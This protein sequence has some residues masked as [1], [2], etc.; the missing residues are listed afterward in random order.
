MI[1]R[2]KNGL[3]FVYHK[4]TFKGVYSNFNS[5]IYDQH[6]IGLIFTLL[7]WEFSIVSDFLRFHTKVSRLKNIL[8]KNAFPIKL[9]DN[10]IKTFLKKK[11]LHSAVALTV[12]KKVLFVVL[13]YVGNFSLALRTCLRSSFNKNL[14]Y[15]KIKVIFKSTR[16]VLVIF[17]VLRIKI[18]LGSNVFYR[19][20]CGKCSDT[21]YGKTCRHLNVRVGKHFN[22]SA[23]V[24]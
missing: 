6:K 5:F 4:P 16:H 12:E 21:Y 20:S 9:V 18:N 11:V 8:R 19:F 24:K 3:P 13:P 7:F 14:P 2:S 22:I 15:F 17:S 23:A 10:C 1:S